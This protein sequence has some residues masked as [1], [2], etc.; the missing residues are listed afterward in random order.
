MKLANSILALVATLSMAVTAAAAQTKPPSGGIVI[1]Q[2][3]N[4]VQIPGEYSLDIVSFNPVTDVGVVGYYT[5]F[6]VWTG[7]SYQFLEIRAYQPSPGTTTILPYV[8]VCG[9]MLVDLIKKFNSSPHKSMLSLSVSRLAKFTSNNVVVHYATVNTEVKVTSTRGAY[10]RFVNEDR[11]EGAL[12]E[13]VLY[14]HP[15][16]GFPDTTRL[17]YGSVKAQ[18]QAAVTN[19]L[20][21]LL[22]ETFL[23]RNMVDTRKAVSPEKMAELTKR[24]FNDT[25]LLVLISNTLDTGNPFI[26]IVTDDSGF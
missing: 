23:A 6:K 24:I 17:I 21:L 13:F 3:T 19:D 9:P 20:G 10:Y 4:P 12:R 14:G 1:S 22:A 15:R 7:S 5:R 25:S 8:P 11:V 18:H 26:R 2:P 16:Q